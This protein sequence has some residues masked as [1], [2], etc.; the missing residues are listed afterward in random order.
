MMVKVWVWSEIEEEKSVGKD[1]KPA[2]N[3]QIGYWPSNKILIHNSR[4]LYNWIFHFKLL[5]LGDYET[6][7]ELLYFSRFCSLSHTVPSQAKPRWCMLPPQA[8]SR[9]NLWWALLLWC[10]LVLSCFCWNLEIQESLF[11][12]QC[13]CH[14]YERFNFNILS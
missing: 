1:Q 10:S 7:L 11:T 9:E 13:C 5:L 2:R 12:S 14:S 8:H 3:I 6:V 4:K